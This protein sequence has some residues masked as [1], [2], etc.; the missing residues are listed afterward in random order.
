M[1]KDININQNKTIEELIKLFFSKI[2]KPELFN[3]N[4]VNFLYSAKVINKNPKELVSEIFKKVF[5]NDVYVVTIVDWKNKIN[6]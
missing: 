4:D 2:N 6:S 1:I 3:D 5:D